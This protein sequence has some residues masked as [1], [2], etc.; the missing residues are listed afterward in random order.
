ML[1]I[2]NKQGSLQ[3]VLDESPDINHRRIVNLSIVILEYGS[4]YLE[5]E[6]VYNSSLNTSFFVKWFFKKIKLYCSDSKR[7]SSLSTNTCATMRNT[8]TELEEHPLLKHA[9]FVPCDSYGLQLLIKDILKSYP[10]YDIISKAQTIVSAF[11]R[12]PK[13]YAIL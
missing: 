6:F 4:F 8:W 7:M 12:A 3:F 1:D 2:L 11:H 5:N 10:F 13:Q 9:F